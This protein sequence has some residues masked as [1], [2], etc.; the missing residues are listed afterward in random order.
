MTPSR[1]IGIA[2]F[3]LSY[4]LIACISIPVG[5]SLTAQHDTVI[6]RLTEV[7]E[8]VWPYTDNRSSSRVT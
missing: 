8:L 6:H 2:V 1:N 5:R 7:S 3:R 4:F